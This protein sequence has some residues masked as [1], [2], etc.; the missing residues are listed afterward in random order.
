MSDRSCCVNCK[1]F[2]FWP[3]SP[4]YSEFT[5]GDDMEMSCLRKHWRVTFETSE[6]DF[7]DYMKSS[8]TCADFEMVSK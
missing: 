7:R 3:G 8:E 6:D 5:P 4:G 2:N 1:H